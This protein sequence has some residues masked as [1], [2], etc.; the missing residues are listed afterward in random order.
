MSLIAATREG[1]IDKV[2]LLIKQGAD[3]NE[4]IGADVPL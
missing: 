2:K 1:N 3:V 4:K